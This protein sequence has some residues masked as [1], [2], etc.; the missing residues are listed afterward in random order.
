[1]ANL[2]AGPVK[3]PP[4]FDLQG[5][6]AATEWKFWRTTFEDYLVAVGQHEAADKVKLSILRNIIGTESARIMST[7][8]I[9]E[10]ETNNYNFMIE[11]IN[12]YVNPR[13]NE[14]FERYNFLQRMQKEGESFEHFLTDCRYLVKTCNYNNVDQNES[15]EEKAL[16]DKI[17]MGIRDPTTRE[18]LLRLDQLTLQKAIQFCR[19]SEQSKTQSLQFQQNTGEVNAVK[20]YKNKKTVSN[21]S[22]KYKSNEPKYSGSNSSTT[23]FK[24]KRCQNLHGPRE[25][26]AYG[27][28]C[29]KC[30]KLNH[31]AV[32]C[33]VKNIKNVGQEGDGDGTS[34]SEEIFVGNINA[35]SSSKKGIWDE[36]IE[37]EGKEFK[38]RLDTGADVNVLPMKSFKSINKQCS[39]KKTDYVLKAFEGTISKP[40]GVVNLCCRYKNRSV[41]EK[42]VIVEGA[43][44][45]LL[46]GQACLHLNLMKRVDKIS[47]ELSIDKEKFVKENLDIF[48]GTGKFPGK[49][50]ITTKNFEAVSHPPARIPHAIRAALKNEL[51]RLVKRKAIVMVHDID[52]R[53]SINRMVIVEKTNGK[54]RLCLD[55][56]DL[57]KQIVRKPR[58]TPSIEETFSKL[59]GKSIF[60]VFD[61]SEGY[62]HLELDDNSSWKCC[63]A[64]PF[65]I[66]R[67]VVLP[68]G[69]SNSQDL[70]QEQVEKHFGDIENVQICHDD[71]IVAGATKSEHDIAV[72]KVLERARQVNAKFN[73]EKFQYCKKQ[74]KFMGQIFSEKGMQVDPERVEALCKLE[75]PKNRI[76]LQRVLGSFNYV[77]RYVPNMAVIMNPLYELLKCNVEWQWLPRHQESFENIKKIICKSPALVPFDF[78]RKTVLQCDSS[79]DGIGCCMF[80]E[81]EN[82]L[83]KLVACA[84][85]TMND[86]E[87]NYSQTEKEL[88]S[89][90]FGTQKFHDFIYHSEVDVQTDHKPLISIMK[91]PICKIG[92]V[93][94]QR[95]RI[96]LL[97]YSLNVYYIP[98]KNIHFADML[99]RASLKSTS[100][101]S[102]MC[103]MVHY[104]SKHLPISEE[105]KTEFRKETAKDKTLGKIAEF[106]FKGWPKECSI[107]KDCKPFYNLRND[108]YVETGLLF[109]DDK[110]IVPENLRMPMI[111]LLHKGHVGISKTI[112]KAR[113]F[114]FWPN[115]ANDITSFIKQCRTCEKYMPSS[116]K[117]PLLPH[118]VPNLRFNKISTDILE[119]GS[120]TYLILI[121]HF[122]HWIEMCPLT[123]KTSDAVIN[124][125]QD[126]FSKFGY[127]QYLIADNLPF[128]SMKCKQ[129]YRDKDISVVTCTP[130]YHQSN[131]LAEKAVSIGKQI[132][133]K[134]LE[135]KSDFRELV[136]EYNNT[137]I[138]TL[139]A[140]PAQILQ[141]RH[142]RTQLPITSSKLEP[143]IQ[144]HI[145]QYLCKQKEK[146]KLH[147]DK[148]SRK[149]PIQFKR[150]EKV[151]IK[152]S[153]DKIWYKATVLEKAKEPRSYWVRKESNNK[154]I[155]RNTSQMKRSITKTD[156]RDCTLEPEL[157]PDQLLLGAQGNQVNIN[158]NAQNQNVH[159]HDDYVTVNDQALVPAST[160]PG[161]S[162]FKK[163]RI[164][165]QIKPPLRLDL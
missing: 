141:S 42:F 119:F 7:F 81:Y 96:K 135:E 91:K 103:E 62:H 58:L 27:K 126:I 152:S 63:F 1:M 108:I 154:I 110:L 60:T 97:K 31:F 131:G 52:P 140:S 51:D 94:L 78:N 143:K 147:Y 130:Y 163:S 13:I 88:L 162:S 55:P 82:K 127:P 24:C 151:V 100:F 113:Q 41:Y 148:S 150:G 3:L 102:E 5:Q 85:R 145:Y 133:R 159:L 77:R 114:F 61:L 19:T 164:G 136:L 21:Y 138:V 107:S 38:I 134:S 17:V 95:L 45:I 56:S 29:N 48:N 149:L 36:I 71:M 12:K 66:Y 160:I 10:A 65:G 50:Q 23:K 125:M 44:Q 53:A 86:H 156:H 101:D 28:K 120:K 57:N 144:S 69:L 155:R 73:K 70:F 121:D 68:Y 54:L 109:V 157:Y 111:K 74:V 26:P 80:Q 37:I 76:E 92:S 22:N 165:R 117:E 25:C 158:G 18:A 123:S 161:T 112:H 79:K 90:H 49:C 33:K 30:N 67:F 43:N 16:R 122:S 118:S 129:Y 115:L 83:L 8:E 116:F 128:L 84:S 35:C 75:S 89:I 2:G 32:S 4:D 98:G 15:A 39:I 146:I 142:L 124:A 87:V 14:C 104:I 139:D 72:A 59:N 99:S 40:V 137:P 46:G 106:Y 153:F 20:N 93:R 6:N 9:P 105:K 132:L 11:L 34:S 64:T 47:S